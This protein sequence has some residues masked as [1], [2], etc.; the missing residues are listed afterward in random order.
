VKAVLARSSKARAKPAGVQSEKGHVIGILSAK[1]GLGNSTLATNLGITLR[2]RTKK[3]VI[4]AELRPGEGSIGL[5]LGFTQPEGLNLLMR[6]QPNE[7]KSA[8]V[9]REL[10]AHNSGVRFLLSS[11][12][13]VDARFNNCP[14]IYGVIAQQI[15]Y[16]SRYVVLDLG[17]GLPNST[18]KAL[19][20]CDDLIVVL[21]PVPYTITRTKCLLDDL[22]EKGFGEGRVNLV[23][24][25]RIRT[26]MQLSWS[27]VKEML[28]H[29]LTI[30]FTPAPE[31]VYQAARNN[32][33]LVIQQPES[34]TS[35]L[36]IKLADSLLKKEPQKAE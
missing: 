6:K 5:D 24:V 20:V 16:L 25:N 32:V 10:I 8:E 31:L 33:P 23:M 11:Y 29:D 9:D 13:P 18:E 21:E 36:F 2:N 22:H 7:L 14:D 12:Q 26:E 28:G 15:A 27:Q 35:Q 4:V 30:T 3:T 19:S 1:G 34:L 17:P